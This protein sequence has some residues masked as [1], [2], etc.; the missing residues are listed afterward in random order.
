M[1]AIKNKVVYLFFI[2]VFL[3]R[4]GK[5]YPDFFKQWVNDYIENRIERRVLI[6]R[7]TGD[8]KK[9]F[10]AIAIDMGMDERNVFRYHKRA[11]ERLTAL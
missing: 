6:E 2:H 10:A 7:Y 1:D 3:R 11:V 5:R 8:T 9:K 4:L